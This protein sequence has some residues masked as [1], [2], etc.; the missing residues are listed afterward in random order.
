MTSGGVGKSLLVIDDDERLQRRWRKVAAERNYVCLCVATLREATALLSSEGHRE[1]AW[2][3]VLI[4]ER[5]PD[6]SGTSLLSLLGRLTSKPTVIVVSGHLDAS[7]CIE[8]L[9]R[10]VAAVSKP[11]GFQQ[12]RELL[13]IFEARCGAGWSLDDYG[14]ACELSRRELEVL[15]L[16]VLGL[17]QRE[18]AER[19]GCSEGSVKTLAQRVCLKAGKESLR[20]VVG[21]VVSVMSSQ[22]TRPAPYAASRSSGVYAVHE[23]KS[24][25]RGQGER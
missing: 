9:S 3:L 23:D 12:M 21:H 25:R 20:D 1:R 19:L 7:I 8:L 18:I 24:C 13:E 10:G 6:G 14:R 16:S 5:L 11:I 22:A 2:D 4:D 17:R 15:R